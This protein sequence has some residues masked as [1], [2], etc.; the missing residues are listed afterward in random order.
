MSIIEAPTCETMRFQWALNQHTEKQVK[1]S[2]LPTGSRSKSNGVICKTNPNPRFYKGDR[3]SQDPNWHGKSPRRVEQEI[4]LF[5]EHRKPEYCHWKLLHPIK[6]HI[7]E[8]K[9]SAPQNFGAS[10]N[11]PDFISVLKNTVMA[12]VPMINNWVALN[13]YTKELRFISSHSLEKH[14]LKSSQ[15]DIPYFS[16]TRA[17][18]W[19]LDLS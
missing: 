12:I 3:N 16:F 7:N 18:G 9:N 8:T 17:A 14:A 5:K 19:A 11:W 10:S 2:H 13:M 6:H 15:L 4:P 1:S